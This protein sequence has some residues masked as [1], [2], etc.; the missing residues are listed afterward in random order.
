MSIK[1][2]F[3]EATR[4]QEKGVK[5]YRS[6][7]S[8]TENGGEILSVEETAEN[9]KVV[10]RLTGN[11]RSDTVFFFKDE[12]FA[13]ATAD[14]DIT[15]DCEALSTI[16]NGC[17]KGLIEAQQLMDNLGRGTLTITRLPEK[18]YDDFRA[19]GVAGALEIE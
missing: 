2:E 17:Q 4:K 19:S 11:L 15:L 7:W 8:L 18:I 14:S 13:L 16:S 5:S 10:I 3:R 6:C 1:R 12:L 9:K